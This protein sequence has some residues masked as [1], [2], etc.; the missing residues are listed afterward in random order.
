M[1]YKFVVESEKKKRRELRSES[2]RKNANNE[3]QD[4]SSTQ[5]FGKVSL[6]ICVERTITAPGA[7]AK[8]YK[9]T[10][11]SNINYFGVQM[12]D[13]PEAKITP[14]THLIHEFIEQR[15]LD[16]IQRAVK[17]NSPDKFICRILWLYS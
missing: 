2:F 1:D 5:S 13:N 7:I 10:F 4:N 17:E 3:Y 11:N 15:L 8:K 14:G 12:F 9:R 6:I 16:D